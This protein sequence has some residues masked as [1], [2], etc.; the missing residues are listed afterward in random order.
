ML[1]FPVTRRPA[2]ALVERHSLSTRE[3]DFYFDYLSPYAF[4]ASLQIGELCERHDVQ[5]RLR[6]VL[7]GGLLNHWGQLGPAEIAPKAQHVFKECLRYALLKGR[8]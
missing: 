8:G 5:L 4:L 2:R 6:P 3:L 1:F 7:F